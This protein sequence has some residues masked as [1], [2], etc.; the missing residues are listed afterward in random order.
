[1]EKEEKKRKHPY[2]SVHAYITCTAKGCQHPIKLNVVERSTRGGYTC[3]FHGML[4]KGKT[5]INGVSIKEL[6]S[7]RNRRLTQH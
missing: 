5:H 4:E 1:M 6:L 2:T 7:S 3:Y